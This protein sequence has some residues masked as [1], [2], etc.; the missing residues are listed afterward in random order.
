MGPQSLAVAGPAILGTALQRLATEE[1]DAPV[2]RREQMVGGLESASL[3][4]Y[5]TT[6]TGSPSGS[7]GRPHSTSRD[8]AASRAVAYCAMRR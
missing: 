7:G 3:L 5:S 8:P 6:V 4:S 2:A 1:E